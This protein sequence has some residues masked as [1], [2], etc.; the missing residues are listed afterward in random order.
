MEEIINKNQNIFKKEITQTKS[1]KNEQKQIKVSFDKKDEYQKSTEKIFFPTQKYKNYDDVFFIK[2]DSNEEI[3]LSEKKENDSS[4]KSSCIIFSPFVS[5][6]LCNEEFIK[7]N[8][9]NG[10]SYKNKSKN[11]ILKHNLF[12]NNKIK[13]E[14]IN[15]KK[16]NDILKDIEFIQNNI[17]N[18]NFNNVFNSNFN[19]NFNNIIINNSNNELNFVNNKN[20][21]LNKLPNEQF[22]QISNCNLDNCLLNPFINT[23]KFNSK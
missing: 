18:N 17:N 9:P 7:E 1:I 21:N 4:K 22:V 12:N 8:N 5:Y 13:L 19:N 16:V 15:L 10:N 2:E 14:D 23:C 20:S 3:N 11:Y 6:F